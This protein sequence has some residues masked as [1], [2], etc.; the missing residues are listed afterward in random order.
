M[1][2]ARLDTPL[3]GTVTQ[4]TTAGPTRIPPGGA[5]LVARG[6]QS[7]AQLKAEAPV[8]QQVEALLSLSPD[9]SGL[10]ERDRRRARCS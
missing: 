1:P 6:T 8:G 3:D 7:T 2:P 10:R 4:V 9:W 5:V